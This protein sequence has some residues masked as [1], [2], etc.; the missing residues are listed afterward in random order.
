MTSDTPLKVLTVIGTRPEAI[1]MAP[2]ILRLN[3]TSGFLPRLCVTAQHREMLDQMLQLFNLKPDI[4]LGLMTANQ[5]LS[6]ITSSILKGMSDVLA[7]EKPDWVL[8]QGDT[9]TVMATAMSAFYAGIR[10]GHVEAGLRSYNR[11][12]PFPEEI[13]RR[14]ATLLSDMHFAP[15]ALARENLLKEGVP[16]SSCVVTGNP[17][18]DALQLIASQPYDVKGSPL[19]SI[20]FEKK[21]I[22]LVTAHRR[23]NY[24]LP[25]ENICAALR[26]ISKRFKDSVHIVYPVHLNPVV[27][28]TVMP[29]LSGIENITLLDPL[30]YRSLIYLLRHSELVLTDSGGLQ[31][32]APGLGVPVMVLRDVTERPEGIASGNLKLVG[33]EKTTIL[34][35]ATRLLEDERARLQMAN[36]ANPY[37]DGRAAERIVAALRR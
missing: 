8:V 27:R 29:S 13:N 30:D 21:R 4:D 32:E 18:I 23:E 24:G 16:E 34:S 6:D 5:S 10:V 3:Q 11:L 20:P 14:I 35:E 2:V 1:K 15:T 19:D 12:A 9:T 31:E 22:V 26:E 28:S 33:T 36:A 7:Q 17:V 25:L 37:G